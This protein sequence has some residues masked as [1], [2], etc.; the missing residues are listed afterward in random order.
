M[1]ND[2]DNTDTEWLNLERASVNSTSLKALLCSKLPFTQRV[3]N[4]TS[5][6]VVLHSIKIWN[7]FR[8]SFSLTDLS[9]ATPLARN[10]MF[11]PSLIDEV[12]DRWSRRGMLS[13]SD[14]Y[15]DGNF[16]SFEQLVQKYHIPKS[17][18]YLTLTPRV[19]DAD[20]IQPLSYTCSGHVRSFAL[21]GS[22]SLRLF[23]R[24]LGKGL[25]HL[26]L[27]RFLV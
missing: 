17:H 11:I 15:I 6:P 25:H 14:L 12:F 26:H 8:R 3:S 20:R 18:F 1:G 21:S 7:Q 23:L 2:N 5:N 22:P 24:F 4:F 27:L 19:I 16:A 9:Q 10:H 13:L